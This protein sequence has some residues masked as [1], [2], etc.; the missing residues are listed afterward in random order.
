MSTETDLS[1][2]TVGALVQSFVDTIQFRKT[3]K[4]VGRN[5]RLTG[6]IWDTA[7]ELK[8]RDPALNCLRGLLG[9]PRSRGAVRRSCP[10]QECRSYRL[11]ASPSRFGESWMT[12]SAVTQATFLRNVIRDEKAGKD[13]YSEPVIDPELSSPSA[14][15]AWQPRHPPPAAMSLAEIRRQ[16]ARTMSPAFAGRVQSL[17]RPAIGLWPQRPRGDLPRHCVAA[18]RHAA[19][20]AGMVVAAVRDRADVLSRPDQLRGTAGPSGGR[21]AAAIGSAGILRRS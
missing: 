4:H 19:C 18:R 6:Q 7:V 10:I 14:E 8:A 16:L 5:N 3:I 13:S 21:E 1:A 2:L 9:H 11:Q 15:A 20:A 17:A 12:R